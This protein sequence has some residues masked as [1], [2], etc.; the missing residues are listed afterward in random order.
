MNRPAAFLRGCN[1][2]RKILSS[3]LIST[4]QRQQR[5]RQQRLIHF[6]DLRPKSMSRPVRPAARIK[7]SQIF[8]NVV[9]KRAKAVFYA[10]TV[11]FKIEQKL[12]NILAN[13]QENMSTNH[14][15]S[16][17]IWSHWFRHLSLE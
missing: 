13:V 11:V 10:K 14:F 9:Q 1:F 5:R 2:G 17:L 15:K 3:N 8:T 16:S 12:P 7:C 6:R 4:K